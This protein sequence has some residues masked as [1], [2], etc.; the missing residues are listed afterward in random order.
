MG[1]SHGQVPPFDISTVNYSPIRLRYGTILSGVGSL[2]T[3]STAQIPD[4]S[5]GIRRY[6]VRYNGSSFEH[7]ATY[8]ACGI[9]RKPPEAVLDIYDY[10]QS[11]RDTSLLNDRSNLYGPLVLESPP[12]GFLG[13][14]DQVF[15]R[16]LIGQNMF[17]DCVSRQR[18]IT[19]GSDVSITITKYY[20][21]VCRYGVM[22]DNQVFY[23]KNATNLPGY[24][25]NL[26]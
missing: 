1:L 4:I 2:R 8:K 18:Y 9:I 12:E 15:N 26:R 6:I 20:S 3:V 24:A 11:I 13:V 22:K 19:Q 16:P 25:G 21:L 5:Y 17:L 14:L 10:P 23:F 7:I